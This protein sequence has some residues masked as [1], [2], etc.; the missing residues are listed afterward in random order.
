[1][2]IKK[3][4]ILSLALMIAGPLQAVEVIVLDQQLVEQNRKYLL[5]EIVQAQKSRRWAIAGLA[6]TLVGVVGYVGYNFMSGKVGPLGMLPMKD[7]PGGARVQD[8]DRILADLYIRSGGQAADAHN[9]S[10]ISK[11]TG[12]VMD[13]GKTVGLLLVLGGAQFVASYFNNKLM[14]NMGASEN[15]ENFE[16]FIAFEK[17]DKDCEFLTHAISMYKLAPGQVSE[18]ELEDFINSY[19]LFVKKIARLCGYLS[20]RLNGWKA[21]KRMNPALELE[22]I[23]TV[24]CDRSKTC[25]TQI[26]AALQQQTQGERV[27]Q[28]AQAV[29]QFVEQ[30]HN[31]VTH[32]KWVEQIEKRDSEMMLLTRNM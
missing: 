23:I 22:N 12:G 20:M 3:A 10:F 29:A 11:V 32:A 7:A 27:E 16:A 21:R 31:L 13:F 25:S 9:Q 15:Y 8:N 26:E 19:S 24:I 1:M 5:C 28:S 2:M 18:E 4:F 14:S 30:L 6:A 17:F